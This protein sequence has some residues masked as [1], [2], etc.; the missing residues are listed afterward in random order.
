MRPKSSEKRERETQIHHCTT[1][2]FPIRFNHSSLSTHLDFLD[3]LDLL[4]LNHLIK[5]LDRKGTA[6]ERG[7]YP[8][9]P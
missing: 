4:G 5:V 8:F 6:H 7:D 9:E 3:G 1:R 2:K